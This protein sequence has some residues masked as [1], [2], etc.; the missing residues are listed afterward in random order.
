MQSGTTHSMF[1]MND[2][3]QSS[4]DDMYAPNQKQLSIQTDMSSS[5]NVFLQHQ[6]QKVQTRSQRVPEQTPLEMPAPVKY[7][8]K[9]ATP[10]MMRVVQRK[11][12][13]GQVR[14]VYVSDRNYGEHNAIEGIVNSEGENV[15]SQDCQDDLQILT[16]NDFGYQLAT[17]QAN[18]QSSAIRDTNEQFVDSQ[19]EYARNEPVHIMYR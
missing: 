18:A 11:F 10:Q 14:T 19:T 2:E 15:D 12:D 13:D 9:P 7:N 6:A 16:A 17:P 4:S 8:I 1:T 5:L 3:D